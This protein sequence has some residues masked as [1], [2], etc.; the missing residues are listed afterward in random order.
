MW[1]GNLFLKH[2]DKDSSLMTIKQ[3]D[4]LESHSLRKEARLKPGFLAERVGFKPTV[5]LGRTPDFESGPFDHSGIFP[6]AKVRNFWMRTNMPWIKITTPVSTGWP[7]RCCRGGLL[8]ARTLMTSLQTHTCIPQIF[9][10]LRV[11]PWP[12]P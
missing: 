12:G 11:S 7:A 3:M 10:R 4:S 1:L 6:G 5:R 9:R 2:K 8:R